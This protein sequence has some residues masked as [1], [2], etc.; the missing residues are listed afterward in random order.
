MR[1]NIKFIAITL[2]I[3]SVVTFVVVQKYL[4][5]GSKKKGNAAKIVNPTLSVNAQKVQLKIL[6]DKIITTGTFLADE[7]IQLKSEIAGKIQKINFTEGKN[8]AANQLLIKLKSDDIEAQ[9]TQA[10]EKL[11]LL[12]VT[13]KR[14]KKLLAKDGISQEE[15]DISLNEVLVQKA[16]LEYLKAMLDKTSIYAPF[17]GVAGL[18]YF[19]V[20]SF[21]STNDIISN[22]YK[23]DRLKLEFSVPQKYN[24]LVEVGKEVEF[25][26]STSPTPYKATIYAVDPGINTSTRTLVI[27]AYYQ[28]N[29]NKIRPGSFADVNLNITSNSEKLMVPTQSIIPDIESEKVYV[30]QD[31]KAILQ[32]VKTGLRTATEIEIIDGLN[33]GDIV[34]TSGIIQ[35]RPNTPVNITLEEAK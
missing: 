23:T 24:S 15:Y 21:I 32:K 2:I 12:E 19:S 10:K 28:N 5:D 16:Q 18:R 33:E 1:R 20:G 31:G 7:S 6:D 8:V 11:S 9:I 17:S 14:Q 13:E 29:S 3:A 22:L 4:G 25:Y 35:L 34:I 30:Y 26:L 27:R